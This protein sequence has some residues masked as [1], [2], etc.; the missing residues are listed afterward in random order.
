MGR[1]GLH[2]L[3]MGWNGGKTDR[4]ENGE[5]E[6]RTEMFPHFHFLCSLFVSIAKQQWLNI[7]KPGTGCMS[8]LS[9]SLSSSGLL[10][11]STK[12]PEA[13]TCLEEVECGVKG[14]LDTLLQELLEHPHLINASLIKTLKWFRQ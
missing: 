13:R 14:E 6:M 3:S 7:N 2:C 1:G 12:H 10:I 11:V 9:Q 8:M 4:D 5:T